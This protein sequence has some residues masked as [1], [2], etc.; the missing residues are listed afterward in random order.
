MDTQK[1]I[2]SRY[3][4]LWL[5][6]AKDAEGN[7]PGTGKAACGIDS[8]LVKQGGYVEATYQTTCPRCKKAVNFKKN[9]V[10]DI[11]NG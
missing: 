8:N 2:I 4:H 10:G 5:W 9:K 6:D 3:T 1:Q 11:T 7:S